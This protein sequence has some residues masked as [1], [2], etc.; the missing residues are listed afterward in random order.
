MAKG[1][2]NI[3]DIDDGTLVNRAL[4]GETEAFDVLVDRYSGLVYQMAYGVLSNQED[5][6]DAAQET[7]VRAFQA[8]EKFRGES[9]FKTWLCRIAINAARNKRRWY[10][11]RARDSHVSLDEPVE[12]NEDEMSRELPDDRLA[13]DRLVAGAELSERLNAAL[14]QL[15]EGIRQAVVMYNIEEMSYEEIAS[16][17][18][19]KMG[20]VKSRISR[21]R[22][23]LRRL[24]GIQ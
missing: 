7:F 23:E 9:S 19:C 1:L 5:A 13:P 21:G 4:N 17:L 2:S 20:T 14:E 3:N 24:L 22:D 8:L 11:I 12:G 15:P 6:E 16:A 10:A 18:D